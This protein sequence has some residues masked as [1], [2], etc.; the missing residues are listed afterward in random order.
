LREDAM[1]GAES[2]G[3]LPDDHKRKLEA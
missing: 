2:V 3:V 1:L